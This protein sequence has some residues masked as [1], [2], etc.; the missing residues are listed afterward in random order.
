MDKPAGTTLLDPIPI[1]SDPV[2]DVAIMAQEDTTP[3]TCH[4]E[5]SL[6]T[7]H[8][9]LDAMRQVMS[10]R[11]CQRFLY[12]PYTL[13]CGHTFCYSCLSQWI[14]QNKKKTC[15]D[16]R[17]VVQ[18]QPTP[19]WLIREMVFIFVNKSE[20]LPDGETSEEHHQMAR[21]E[22]EIVAKD[23]ANTDDV[24]GGLFMGAFKPGRRPLQALHDPSDHVDRCP[25][26][27][28]EV[29]D[30]R[31]LHCNRR[32]LTELDDSDYSGSSDSG[33]ESEELDH[34]LERDGPEYVGFNYADSDATLEEHVPGPDG[35]I[36][37]DEMRR[38]RAAGFRTPPP[39]Y[40]SDIEEDDEENSE[41]EGFI[42]DDVHYES[43]YDDVLSE[44]SV[45]E[46][47]APRRQRSN[48]P[49]VL[50][51]DDDEDDV[52]V[53][54][55]GRR[56]LA[57]RPARP[58]QVEVSDDD[59]SDSDSDEEP[60]Q[61]GSQRTR[62]GAQ[63]AI[64]VSSSQVPSEDEDGQSRQRYNFSP[65]D[66]EDDDLQRAV[67]N[68]IHPDSDEDDDDSD[69]EAEAMES[70][71]DEHSD[72]S[73]GSDQSDQQSETYGW[74][75]FCHML[76][77]TTKLTQ[78]LDITDAPA[79]QTRERAHRP[80]T[81]QH[82]N[83]PQPHDTHRLRTNQRRRRRR[84]STPEFLPIPEGYPLGIE[85]GESYMPPLPPQLYSRN[86]LLRYFGRIPRMD[87]P[88]PSEDP[89][90][91]RRRAEWQAEARALERR[92]DRARRAALADQAAQ[93]AQA[94]EGAQ[95]AQVAAP[96]HPFQLDSTLSDI[97][98]RQRDG[99]GRRI[100]RLPWA[101]GSWAEARIPR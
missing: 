21:E 27:L 20:L 86:A 45:Q 92:E 9:D 15:P 89:D 11:V 28:N 76:N 52:Q 54:V 43:G 90:T 16:C 55:P 26:C 39:G 78:L 101:E 59:S 85:Y 98:S 65:V 71:G 58:V 81:R 75:L 30:G 23:K 35:F 6:R 37:A 95:A 96:A 18:E 69:E 66:E 74:A 3:E 57:Q 99:T 17:A 19:A 36:T 47:A 1:K 91:P 7:L 33:D 12:E 87:P 41:M 14:G 88:H 100:R 49:V 82:A 64:S 46:Q 53:V 67:H 68:S 40:S 4:H 34:D 72:A 84:R 73:D 80:Q 38:L 42:D 13:T 10:C 44:G 77:P 63:R 97:N 24:K 48:A 29:E 5:Q 60:V 2:P 8:S 51:D 32:V 56:R 83:Q 70:E 62:G 61:R 93:I 79:Q 31:C 94:V 22:A 25:Q 50:S